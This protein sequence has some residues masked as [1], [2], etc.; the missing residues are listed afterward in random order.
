MPKLFTMPAC[1][2]R[3]ATFSFLGLNPSFEQRLWASL[4]LAEA[5]VKAGTVR[6]RPILLTALAVAVPL[7]YFMAY[8]RQPAPT[9]K[10][11]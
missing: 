11:R 4:T 1:G 10:T 6:F 9:G 3:I 5:V 2:L 7:L 8:N